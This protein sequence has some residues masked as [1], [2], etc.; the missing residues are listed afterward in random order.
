MIVVRLI[1]GIGN[2]M[3]QYAFA[4]MLSIKYGM[5]IKIDLSLLKRRDMGSNFVYRDYD[6][7]IFN[8]VESFNFD[9]NKKYIVINEPHFHYSPD[10]V[11]NIDNLLFEKKSDVLLAFGYWQSVK[12]FKDFEK[13]IRK[14]FTFK[15]SIEDSN[16]NEIKDILNRI[17][18]SNSVMINVRRKE[19]L[20]SSHHGVISVDYINKASEIIKSKVDNIEYYVFSDDIEWCKDNIKLENVHFMDKYFLEDMG[21]KFNYYLQLMSRCKHFIISNSTFAWWSAWL[22]NSEDKI[23]IAPKRWLLDEKINTSDII[24]ENWIK[25]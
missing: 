6:M 25:I 20:N 9:L 10:L 22:N 7:N 16:N 14:E 18:S 2:Q 15:Y 19:Y 24:P 23:V 1:G 5:D 21:F 12:Y 8:I 17:D 3:F 13:E 4:R 11:Y